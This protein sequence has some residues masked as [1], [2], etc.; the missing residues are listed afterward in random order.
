MFIHKNINTYGFLPPGDLSWEVQCASD[1]VRIVNGPTWPTES[2]EAM[3]IC[4]WCSTNQ[5][6]PRNLLVLSKLEFYLQACHVK[7]SL[8]L[9]VFDLVSILN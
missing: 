5:I 3:L 2:T 7:H 1:H 4:I 9:R 8:I 6:H